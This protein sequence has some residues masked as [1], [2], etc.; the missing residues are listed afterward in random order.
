MTNEDALAIFFK[1]IGIE[2]TVR[3]DSYWLG[4]LWNNVSI[5]WCGMDRP[6]KALE[7]SEKAIEYD[8][9]RSVHFY[10][11]A[12]AYRDL[13]RRAEA[14]ADF[15]KTLELDP[16]DDDAKDELAKLKKRKAR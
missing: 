13:G 15:K 16:T 10:N 4:K 5:C 11:R 1:L 14:K 6:E 2:E 12:I 3:N 8:D 9:S 7:A